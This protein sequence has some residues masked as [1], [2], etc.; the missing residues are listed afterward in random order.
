MQ[1]IDSIRDVQTNYSKYDEW[2]KNQ[3]DKKAKKEYLAQN[4]P[5]PK[6]EVELLKN[7]AKSIIR[8]TEI[9]DKKSEDN[10]ENSEMVTGLVSSVVLLGLLPFMVKSVKQAQ[11]AEFSLKSLMKQQLPT[12]ALLVPSIGLILWGTK[13]QI[14]ASRIG[15]FQARKND[16]K[17][18]KNFVI[19]TPEQIEAAKILARNIPD[20]NDKKNIIKAFKEM[21]QFST[22]KKAYKEWLED[23]IKNPEDVDKLLKVNFSEDQLKQASA[24]K[25][26]ILT[27]VKEINNKAEDYSENMENVFDTLPIFAG[28]A[29]SPLGFLVSKLVSGSKSLQ[30]RFDSKFITMLASGAS[31]A[32]I[33]I[34]VTLAVAMTGTKL[35][36]EAAKVGRYQAR[37]EIL[38]NPSML[39]DYNSD[40]IKKA[41]NIKSDN[42]K[43]S[44]FDELVE[45]YKFLFGY[46]KEKKEYDNYIKTEQKENEK[47]QEALNQSNVSDKQLTEAKHFQEKLFHSFDKIDEMSQR[48]SED[49]EGATQVAQ[50]VV[51][52][53]LSIGYSAAIFALPLLF[54][55]G[56]LPL[57]KIAK[58]FSNLF[59]DKTS[60]LKKVIDD[61]FEVVS[62]D[63]EL[64]TQL[65]NIAE[66]DEWKKF[67]T[68]KAVVNVVSQNP[69]AVEELV[70]LNSHPEKIISH[71]KQ[72]SISKWA[73]NLISEVL[74]L[75]RKIIASKEISEFF[76]LSEEV[77]SIAKDT[78]KFNYKNYK[79]LINTGIAGGTSTI[80]VMWLVPHAFN[81]WLTRIQKKA[82]KIG[83]MKAID[84]LDNPK[85]FVNQ[86]AVS[87]S[88]EPQKQEQKAKTSNL[89][90]ALANK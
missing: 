32:A 2:E 68:N 4:N 84:N 75:G 72:G 45:D 43:K 50:Q 38:N 23:K 69:E 5:L 8:A 17:D 49:I 22:E 81:S 7:K 34:F 26:L 53:G 35:Q 24:D 88:D 16:L 57:H 52:T 41:E 70:N 36:K 39:V 19:Y 33:P 87:K 86:D 20:K 13:E 18:P 66:V 76:G 65:C 67:K 3:S 12:L 73:G 30:K 74:N 11:T 58:G 6:D 9:M 77:S 71:F 21:K 46:G 90:E 79:T 44:F 1:M 47:I 56:N 40:E 27:I 15:R 54:L 89:L 85:L 48:Y 29:T 14:E 37:K 42:K 55:T 63:K 25:E 78:P 64:R 59:F 28:L 83:V 80:G 31:G 62:K 60:T 51:S 82:G 61:L 10:A